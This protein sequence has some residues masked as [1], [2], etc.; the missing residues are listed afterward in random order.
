M[1]YIIY[2]IYSEVV[3][4]RKNTWKPPIR[5]RCEIRCLAQI[6]A[7][8][9]SISLPCVAREKLHCSKTYIDAHDAL[10]AQIFLT[11]TETPDLPLSLTHLVI[12]HSSSPLHLI[13]SHLHLHPPFPSSF[14]INLILHLLSLTSIRVRLHHHSFRVGNKHLTCSHYT[15]VRFPYRMCEFEI[16]NMKHLLFSL[17]PSSM[18]HHPQERAL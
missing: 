17:A 5:L 4:Q 8:I 15:V 9:P 1:L 18:P 7:S 11:L 12:L 16:I 3:T 6:F 10:V 14:N 2:Y 13:P